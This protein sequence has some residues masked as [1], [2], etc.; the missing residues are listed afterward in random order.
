MQAEFAA[1]KAWDEKQAA[2]AAEKAERKERY[3][4][5]MHTKNQIRRRNDL[6]EQQGKQI[7]RDVYIE[8]KR[9]QQQS[10]QEMELQTSQMRSEAKLARTEA[11]NNLRAYEDGETRNIQNERKD[12]LRQLK[13]EEI[14]LKQAK[15][16]GL[17]LLI[18]RK[19]QEIE[20]QYNQKIQLLKREV[21]KRR[22]A[23][24]FE[25]RNAVSAIHLMRQKKRV[26]INQ[27]HSDLV[28]KAPKLSRQVSRGMMTID[29]ASENVH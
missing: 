19:R 17:T 4:K 22:S 14:K 12:A 25:Y 9:Q 26:A 29:Q 11:T 20:K 21:Q 13:K 8:A 10:L 6:R 23:I 3:M 7:A 18:T 5:Q 16:N 1:K 15:T 28:K 27:K 24:A 2:I